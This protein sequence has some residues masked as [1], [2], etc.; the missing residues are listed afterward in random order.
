M[1]VGHFALLTKPEDLQH[2][3]VV[4]IEHGRTKVRKVLPVAFRCK[5]EDVTA[6]IYM[7]KNHFEHEAI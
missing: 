2:G 6:S 5:P 7:E 4:M 3:E 1:E